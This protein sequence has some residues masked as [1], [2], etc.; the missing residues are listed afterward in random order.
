MSYGLVSA[1]LG[2]VGNIVSS[3]NASSAAGDASKAQQE[4]AGAAA[5]RSAQATAQARSDLAPYMASGLP[6]NNRLNYL[7]GLDPYGNAKNA[8][9]SSILARF[10]DISPNWEPDNATV[11]QYMNSPEFAGTDYGALTKK[12]SADDLAAD[13][14]YQSG[15]KFGLDQ[16]TEAINNRAAQGGGYDSGAT[17]K[18]LTRFANDYGSTKANDS[19]N[20]DQTNKQSI[21]GMLTGQQNT[22]LAATN[23]ANNVGMAGAAAQGDYATQAGNARA[24]GIV[25]GAQAWGGLGN[26]VTSAY[27]SYNNG[28]ILDRLL[29]PQT[30]NPYY[31]GGTNSIPNYSSGIDA[32]GMY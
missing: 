24:A 19:F 15:L 6:A 22:G 13:P 12:F 9:K 20:R 27:N 5:T 31:S 1:G 23:A 11:Q 30:T 10:P 16:G 28:R 2:L 14:V 18:A 29:Q 7:L 21:Y 3:S 17:L 32:S 4:A 8:I 26:S 25:G